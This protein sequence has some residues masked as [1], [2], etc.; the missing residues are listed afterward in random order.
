MRLLAAR[1]FGSQV[2]ATFGNGYV[3]E[4][5]PGMTLNYKLCIDANVYPKVAKR[6]GEMH[7]A[8]KDQMQDPRMARGHI[9]DTLR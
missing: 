8:M 9:F 2:Y 3:Y 7:R 4:Y 1:R 6:I 5:A